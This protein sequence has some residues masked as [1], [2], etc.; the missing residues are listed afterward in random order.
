[1]A[2]F[3]TQTVLEVLTATSP[4]QSVQSVVVETLTANANPDQRMTG[5]VVEVLIDPGGVNL[6][7]NQLVVEILLEGLPS[8][9]QPVNF[10]M[11]DNNDALNRVINPFARGNL[12]RLFNPVFGR[13]NCH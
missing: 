8:N 13:N 12:I 10:S 3:D 5:L 6:D 9:N 11:S 7:C 2:L 4:S 1:M